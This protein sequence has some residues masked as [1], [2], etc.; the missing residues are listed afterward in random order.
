MQT[1]KHPAQCYNT[2]PVT[3]LQ[4]VVQALEQLS[5]F[6]PGQLGQVLV[7]QSGS[8]RQALGKL[9]HGDVLDRFAA[10]QTT[11]QVAD[12]LI[13]PDTRHAVLQLGR[14]RL[15]IH[16]QSAQIVVA[17]T[18]DAQ[19]QIDLLGVKL[20]EGPAQAAEHEL[21]IVPLG[22]LITPQPPGSGAVV[23]QQRAVTVLRSQL[24]LASAGPLDHGIILA[25]HLDPG[26]LSQTMDTLVVA[27]CLRRWLCAAKWRQVLVPQFCAAVLQMRRYQ[28]IHHRGPLP[29]PA[30]DADTD[31]SGSNHRKI[32]GHIQQMVEGLADI[33]FTPGVDA[34][35][36]LTEQLPGVDR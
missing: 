17:Q 6:V 5:A 24:P 19:D 29:Y 31:G 15:R 13:Q 10:A 23:T 14:R 4:A 20:T 22:R 1:R 21:S 12:A 28:S 36:D 27:R 30:H 26:L 2:G 32:D 7:G 8:A 18:M 9:Q 25:V 34:M 16:M 3:V 11:D 35:I 33:P